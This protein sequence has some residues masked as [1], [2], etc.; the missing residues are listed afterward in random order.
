MILATT[1]TDYNGPSA[2]QVGYDYA[3]AAD[4]SLAL[5]DPAAG[6]PAMVGDNPWAL[7]MTPDGRTLYV[8][9]D[10]SDTV[11]PVVAATNTPGPDAGNSPTAIAVSGTT[12]Y[13]ANAIDSTVTPVNL[14]TGKAAEALPVGTYTYPTAITLSGATAI[15]VEP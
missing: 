12:A 11:P 2:P 4:L 5:S 15:V 10:G 9:N 6:Q 8:A 7:A 14:T 1:L 3:T 13:V